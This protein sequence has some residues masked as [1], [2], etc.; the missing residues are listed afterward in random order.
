MQDDLFGAPPPPAQPPAPAPPRAPARKSLSRVNAA[1]QDDA[2]RALA[3]ALPPRVRLGTSSWTYPGWAGLVWDTEYPDA[4]LSREGLRAYGEHPLLRSVSVDRSFYRPLT[5]D[6]YA[7]YAA[8]VP[9]DF[10]FVV[11]APSHVTDALVRGEDGRGMQPNPAFLDP[12]LATQ[13]FV[14][15]ALAGLGHKV[16]ALVFQLSPLPRHL[17]HNLPL[18]LQRLRRLLL[19][20]PALGP[21]A[22]DGVLAVEVRDPQWLDPLFM[23]ELAAVLRETGATWCLCLHA[24][25]PRLAD[26]LPLLRMLWPGP[27]VCRWNLN[28]LHGAYGYEDAQ[29]EYEPY[30]RIHDVDE[31][32]RELLVR[33]ISGIAGAGQNVFVTISNKAEGCAPLSVRALAQGLARC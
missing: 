13:D 16:G 23:P 10:R 28:P 1:P 17:L 14:A 24:K 2:L 12:D 4:L 29:R 8:Q 18:V 32:T 26:Q 3:S 11:K 19:A 9:D 27:M 25:M 22:P 6:Q 30:D 33:T 15:P 31:E 5:Q 20:Q 21:T 7:R